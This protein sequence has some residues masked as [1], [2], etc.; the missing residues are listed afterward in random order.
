MRADRRLWRLRE[1]LAALD[2]DTDDPN[3][4]PLDLASI[5]VINE[6]QPIRFGHRD[7]GERELAAA[8]AERNRSH[9]RIT[10]TRRTT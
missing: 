8:I 10:T 2:R 4:I 7:E 3:D 6:W 5:T 1:D 9:R